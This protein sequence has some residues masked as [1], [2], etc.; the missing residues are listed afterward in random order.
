MDWSTSISTSKRKRKGKR[1]GKSVR[2]GI[3][4]CSDSFSRD[5]SGGVTKMQLGNGRWETSSF[6]NRSQSNR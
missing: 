5:S 1:K 4:S 2:P 3:L 6:N